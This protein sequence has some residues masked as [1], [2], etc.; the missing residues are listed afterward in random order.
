MKVINADCFN[1][2]KLIT[3]E[4]IDLVVTDP[5]YGITLKPQ[6]SEAKFHK[7]SII[8]DDNLDWVDDFSNELFRISKNVVYVFCSYQKYDIF[9]QSLEKSGF[10]IKN[11]IV[12]DKM[13]FGMGNNYRP[14]HEF[15]ILA[16]KTKF[17]TK[18]NNLENILR[19]RRMS[20]QK[21]VHPTEKP[22]SLLE[23]LIKESSDEGDVIL[24]PF[25]GSGSTG[26][27]CKNLNRKCIL[28]EKEEKYY[29]I[30]KERL[31]DE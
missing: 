4:S 30:I 22:V 1:E 9:K 19:F 24:D 20:G 12:W 25:A 18:S 26:L 8:N 6:R 23:V 11:C 14:N 15:I 28:I 31:K 27:A 17:K 13:W 10:I 7:E 16:I 29:N 2:M 3:N 21:M 5:P